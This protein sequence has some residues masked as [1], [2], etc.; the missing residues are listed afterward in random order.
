[1]A[2]NDLSATPSSSAPFARQLWQVPTFLLGVG[3]LTAFFLV[4]S[5]WSS[6]DARA[7]SRLNQA[8]RLWRKSDPD[9][10][11]VLSLVQQYLEH[12]GTAGP[13]SAEAQLL[14]GS[15]LA[16]MAR[17]TSGEDALVHWREAHQHLV[18]ADRL[19]VSE[20]DKST[21]QVFLGES[22]FHTGDDLTLVCQRIAQNLEEADDKV[23]MSRLLVQANLKKHPADL[24]SALQANETLRQLPLLGEEVLGPAR[25][26]GGEILLRLHRPAEA[27]KLLEKISRDADPDLLTR[28]RT[29]RARSLQDE[30]Q[31]G[32]ACQ[33][34]QEVLADQPHA[35]ADVG[36]AL[37]YQG[38]CH[39]RLEQRD[40]AMQAWRAAVQR[41]Q[42]DSIV[43]ASLG[44]AELLLPEPSD[45]AVDALARAT[46][47]VRMAA[48]W[49]NPYVDLKQV[50]E[51]YE[52]AA[53][54]FRQ[55]QFYERSIQVVRSYEGIAPPG[56]ADYLRG[57]ALLD[58]GRNLRHK[59]S[60]A[61]GSAADL[62]RQAGAAFELS[63]AGVQAA[64]H[65]ER[66]WLSAEGHF[67][68]GDARRAVTVLDRFLKI[69]GQTAERSGEAWY[70]LAQAHESLKDSSAAEAAYRRC[71]SFR[72]KFA[73]RA[74]FR[75]SQVELARG[76]TDR[77]TDML[78]LNVKRLRDDTDDEGMEHSLFS[79]SH[80]LFQRRDYTAVRPLLE[81][82]IGKF[83]SSSL[84]ARGRFE[85]AE[86]YRQLAALENLNLLQGNLRPEARDHFKKQRRMW[87]GKALEQYETLSQAIMSGAANP[88]TR[89][90]QVQIQF[91]VAD[92]RFNLGDYPAAL[93]LYNE[94]AD[95]YKD[96][97]ERLSALGG[98][99]RC[100]AAQRDFTRFKARLQDIRLG[101]KDVDA[102][103]R[104][105]WEEWLA[106]AGK[107][108]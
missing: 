54:V 51:V 90:E 87:V 103:T 71:M 68:G 34:W 84:A 76:N 26:Q 72:S 75:L 106:I 108:Q 55:K 50:R 21:L 89:A 19:G 40:E 1:M 42:R 23:G 10:A 7:E 53:Q 47:D 12:A 107:G 17:K 78:E 62:L 57:Q 43:A 9:L 85:L 20:E 86:T 81:E 48:D 22:G 56:M 96:R 41:G 102:Q 73:Y 70:L 32:E 64:D 91:S 44:L 8:R 101:L 24:E 100:F 5:T 74:R 82:A 79:L 39:R 27:R 36:E 61:S 67:E 31:W 33:L 98:T 30:G 63:A 16:R 94:L 29:L 6:P 69:Q 104:H 97:L 37:Y 11:K 28:A 66:L 35:P 52:H 58:W 93:L 60:A 25:L 92:C 88:F 65:A 49:R 13:R 46:R 3:A 4:R 105:Q 18:Q 15:T 95:R 83:A 59:P 14:W 99:A 80:L 45:A 38:L 2:K 77:A